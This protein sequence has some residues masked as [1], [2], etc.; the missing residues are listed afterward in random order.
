MTNDSRVFSNG[1]VIRMGTL[2]RPR[3]SSRLN[4]GSQN[5]TAN[6]SNNISGKAELRK[7]CSKDLEQEKH[8]RDHRDRGLLLC[9]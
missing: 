8:Q 6:Q 4:Q 2:V 7:S 3:N 5:W 1:L 9:N